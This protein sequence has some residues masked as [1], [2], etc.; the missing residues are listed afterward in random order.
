MTCIRAHIRYLTVF[1][2]AL[3]IG[4]GGGTLMTVHLYAEQNR[5]EGEENA[6]R[7]PESVRQ[8]VLQTTVVLQTGEKNGTGIVWKKEQD[9]SVL[10][11]SCAHLV[12]GEEKVTVRTV[13]GTAEEK[14]D[15]VGYDDR[16]DVAVLRITQPKIAF[17]DGITPRKTQVGYGEEVL[18]CV[19]PG[20]E[21]LMLTCGV[22]GYP[23]EIKGGE[24]WNTGYHRTDILLSP[25]ASGGGV[26][27]REGNLLGMVC[28][29]EEIPEDPDADSR[30]RGY[31]LPCDTLLA[32]AASILEN[33]K[34]NDT[35]GIT[36]L[37]VKSSV[38]DAKV[39]QKVAVIRSAE[40]ENFKALLTGDRVIAADVNGN[41]IPVNH[42]HYLANALYFLEKGDIFTLTVERFGN[43]MTFSVSF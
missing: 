19:N 43:I 39:T 28:F 40:D 5:K 12:K 38:N 6:A 34:E 1:L 2:I 16:F 35:S 20:G 32:T 22:I 24:K 31:A 33:G 26:Y 27:D 10:L 36:F 29:R 42:V 9:G 11:L 4:I 13:E 7:F 21:G 18:A 30:G 15:I 37:A 3:C 25:G 8:A 23:Y 17:C 14:A 41:S